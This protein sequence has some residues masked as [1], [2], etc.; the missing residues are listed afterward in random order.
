MS[1]GHKRW[2]WLLFGVL[3]KK[4]PVDAPFIHIDA[5]SCAII[6]SLSGIYLPPELVK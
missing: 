1:M 2:Q 6:A 5:D 3:G 4:T